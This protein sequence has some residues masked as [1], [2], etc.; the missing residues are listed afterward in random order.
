MSITAMTLS[1]K[2]DNPYFD[3]IAA[4]IEDAKSNLELIHKASLR[5]PL[6]SKE[7]MLFRDS[8]YWLLNGNGGLANLLA[9]CGMDVEDSLDRLRSFALDGYRAYATSGSKMR[10]VRKTN[11]RAEARA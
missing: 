8:Q 1:S 3:L 9:M 5:R 2:S 4:M 6:D 10:R 7:L 11:T